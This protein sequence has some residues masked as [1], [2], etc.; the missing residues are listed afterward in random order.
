MRCLGGRQHRR[1]GQDSVTSPDQFA[2]VPQRRGEG[3][4]PSGGPPPPSAELRSLLRSAPG[5]ALAHVRPPSS[6]TNP[7]YVTS[8]R[9]CDRG[10]HR[11]GGQVSVTRF[12]RTVPVPS[13]DGQEE[14]RGDG[15]PALRRGDPDT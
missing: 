8:M 5:T 13:L 7:K 6:F 3:P 2:T 9:R 4:P 10:R 1:E 11:R 15:S 14:D 12:W